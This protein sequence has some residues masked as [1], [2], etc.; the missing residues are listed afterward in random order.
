MGDLL[1]AAFWSGA[2]GVWIG[3]LAEG[4]RWRRNASDYRRIESRGNLY[5]VQIAARA[6]TNDV[7]REW[8]EIA[9]NESLQ[10]RDRLQR[11]IARFSRLISWEGG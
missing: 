9:R 3:A 1:L 8:C 4:A 7:L 11:L 10:P 2:V 6:V 5:K